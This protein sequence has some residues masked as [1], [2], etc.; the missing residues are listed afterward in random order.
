MKI[1]VIPA[2]GGSKRI[3]MKNI[4]NFS[5]K[6]IIA[7]SIEAAIKSKL[8]DRVIVSTDNHEIASIAKQYGAE[9]PF[10]RP[11]HL[12]DDYTGTNDVVK[13]VIQS[14]YENGEQVSYAC[15]IYATAP[16]VDPKYIINGY[17]RLINSNNDKSYAF[18]VTTY[19]FPVER[20]FL[21]NKSGIIKKIFPK[22]T[23][24]RSQDLREAYHDA[25]Q[26]Y[27][28]TK[29]AFLNDLPIFSEHSIPIIL[30]RYLVQDIDTIEDWKQ[31]ELMFEAYISDKDPDI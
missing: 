16:F 9:V 2:R 4:K 24:R 1:A 20:S 18:S 23:V 11:E 25:G 13:H 19:S 17:Q 6:P 22:N 8:F 31:A 12:S 26:F 10:I 29:N 15:C 30:P 3:P 7:W 27:W 28:G 21:I 14:L 5:G